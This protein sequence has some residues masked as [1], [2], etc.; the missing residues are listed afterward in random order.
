MAENRLKRGGRRTNGHWYAAARSPPGEAGGA[1]EWAFGPGRSNAGSIGVEHRSRVGHARG[2][3]EID[4]DADAVWRRC[5]GCARRDGPR[6]QRVRKGFLLV[7]KHRLIVRVLKWGAFYSRNG[8]A[9]FAVYG[10]V[11]TSPQ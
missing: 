10:I 11:P 3:M 7:G 5:V 4:A 2:E 6:G 8:S 1:R 9:V